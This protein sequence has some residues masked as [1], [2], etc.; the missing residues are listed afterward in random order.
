MEFSI[1]VR[2]VLVL[3]NVFS[4]SAATEVLQPLHLF[5]A[6][7]FS[8]VAFYAHSVLQRKCEVTCQTFCFYSVNVCLC[9][10]PR[11]PEIILGAPQ[12]FAHLLT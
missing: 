8:A 7:L 4:L 6:N 12:I 3:T 9:F 5:S 2:K 11:R 10:P 1:Y